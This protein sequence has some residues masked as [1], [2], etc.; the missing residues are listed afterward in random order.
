MTMLERR[1]KCRQNRL[2]EQIFGRWAPARCEAASFWRR[3]RR[4][5]QHR[6]KPCR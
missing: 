2:A 1:E 6:L 5:A 4:V 3:W